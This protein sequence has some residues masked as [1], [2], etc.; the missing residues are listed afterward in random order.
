M[1]E[2]SIKHVEALIQK[3]AEATDSADAMRFA[4]AAL[5]AANAVL[6]LRPPVA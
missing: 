4:Q 2:D 6:G 3:A 5:N 1:L